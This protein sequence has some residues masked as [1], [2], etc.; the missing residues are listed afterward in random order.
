MV[1]ILILRL[2]VI[3]H[4]KN[5]IN[6]GNKKYV[7]VLYV[8]RLPKSVTPRF[9]NRITTIENCN[10]ITT[11]NITPTDPAKVIKMEKT[12]AQ[13]EFGCAFVFFYLK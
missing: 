9:Y 13:S 4:E 5:Y 3:Y 2:R 6:I 10:I 11:L 12:R 7:R 8:A 1:N